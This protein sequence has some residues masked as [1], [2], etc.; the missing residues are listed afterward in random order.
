MA[1]PTLALALGVLGSSGLAAYVGL[2]DVAKLRR[3]GT[4]VISAATGAVGATV[5]QIA[6]LAGARAVA[7]AG[8]PEKVA[9]AREVLGADIALDHRADDFNRQLA[10]AAADGVDA[11]FDNVGGNVLLRVVDVMKDRGRIAVCGLAAW[12]SLDGSEA[13]A[14]NAAALMRTILRKRLTV[15][16]F[17]VIDWAHREEP[18]HVDMAKWLETGAVSY[19]EDI[20]DGLERAPDV[21]IGL[22][23]GRN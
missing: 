6:K 20:V 23:E 8:G 5:V 14:D 13:G 1:R 17:V 4:I 21:L 2:F 7:V 22:L 15:E 11:Y 16:G 3:G 9:Y 12:Y 10:A 19:R 18:F